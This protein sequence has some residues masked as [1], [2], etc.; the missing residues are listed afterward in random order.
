MADAI[1]SSL[2]FCRVGERTIFLDAGNGRYFMLGDRLEQD[3]ADLLDGRASIESKE[4]LT[5]SAILKSDQDAPSTPCRSLPAATSSLY[6][7][8]RS[9]APARLIVETIRRQY[10]ARRTLAHRPFA[11]AIAGLGCP[12]P[13]FDEAPQCSLEALVAALVGAER[14]M[15]RADDCLAIGIA[16]SRMLGRRSLPHRFVIGVTLSF[17]AHCWVQ[18]GSVVLTDSAERVASFT[19]IL[20]L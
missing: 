1:G 2:H 12:A 16:M 20:V 14:I 5:A 18:S 11:T 17:S 3:F 19:P 9:A 4:R 10:L 7:N 13:Q 8:V 6:E 15:H